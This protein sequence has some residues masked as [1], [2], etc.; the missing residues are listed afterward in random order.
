[1]LVS[2]KDTF[3]FIK[4]LVDVHTMGIHAAASLL[5]DCGYRVLISPSNVE[6][7]I[8]RIMMES[9][10][11]TILDW[12]DDN[13]IT[14]IGF[15]YRLDPDNAVE[16][17][18]RLV[19]LLK[20][21]GYYGSHESKVKHVFFAGLPPAC[22]IIDKEY[23]GRIS[24]FRGGESIE[25]T[26]LVLG[27]PFYAI[28]QSIKNGCQYDN[29]LEKF[30]KNIIKSGDYKYIKAYEHNLYPEF[31][32]INDT[33]ELRL[34]NNFKGG[35]QPIIRAHS[36][37]YSDTMSRK[38]M[39]DE[40]YRWCR[41]LGKSGY[42]D[43]LSI[44]SSQLSQSNFGENWESKPNGGGVPI[45]SEIEYS[46]I[47]HASRPMLVRTY[48]GTKNIQKLAE[49]YERYLNISWHALSLWWFNELDGRGPNTLYDNL[50]EHLETIKWISTTG[51]PVETNVP[52]HFAFRGADDVTYIV[53][54]FLAAKVAKK[55]GTKT[56]VL[57]N[58]LN[59]PRNTWG[60]QDLAKSRTL[61]K[62]VKELEDDNF[63]VILQT[64]AG[65]DYFK[66][67]LEMSKV[68]LAAVTALMDD[69]DPKNEMSPEIIHVVSYSEAIFLATPDILNDSIKI[70]RQSLNE[71]R[72]LKKQ[73]ITSKVMTDDI[74]KR[75]Y[76]LEVACRKIIRAM[77]E[78]IPN[79]YSPDGLYIAFVAGWLPVPDLWSNS[80]EFI[81]AKSW[82]TKM[83]NGSVVLCDHGVLVANDSRINRCVSNLPSAKYIL[84]NK[85]FKTI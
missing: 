40:F 1:M 20:S 31:G 76:D 32:T 23:H 78:T 7:A 64:R 43:V 84:K 3:G 18:G 28:P 13:N 46:N 2:K 50:K 85:Y 67:N 30:G 15:S 22:E 51:K 4:T 65:L 21:R 62:L 14:C 48:S 77:E 8:E 45:N 71:Y 33:L 82:E 68:Q 56:F 52:H 29:E 25:E 36:G 54:G 41:I 47:W 74:M 34:D 60:I 53:S 6:Y 73:G 19:Y 10:Q 79:L 26:L 44:G 69:I 57:Q 16:L 37:P 63:R 24:T 12:I 75:Q 80:E 38:E 35:F 55:Y 49:V 11:N 83:T 39:L 9:A 61:L 66:P 58:M 59:T 72:R 70:T 81:H 42:L 17:M 5:S 27:V